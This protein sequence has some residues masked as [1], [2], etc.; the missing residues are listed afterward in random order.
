MAKKI[1][2]EV[3]LINCDYKAHT[4][5]HFTHDGKEYNLHQD[6]TYSL[7]DCEFVQSLIAQGRLTVKN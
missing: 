4:P 5:C 2:S 1:K 6:E 3:K 7:P